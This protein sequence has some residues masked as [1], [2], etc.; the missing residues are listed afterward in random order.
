MS[1]VFRLSSQVHSDIHI[2]IDISQARTFRVI[3]QSLF[4]RLWGILR[5]RDVQLY[6]QNA[7]PMQPPV[8]PRT[9]PSQLLAEFS[10]VVILN[11]SVDAVTAFVCLCFSSLDRTSCTRSVLFTMTP[12]FFGWPSGNPNS[13]ILTLPAFCS[14]SPKIIAKGTPF[15]SAA[16]NC[17]GS[18]GLSL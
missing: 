9:S 15:T 12:S 11:V 5:R 16:L 4:A 14:S 18:F 10:G 3:L 17:A 13:L 6:S 2:W 7:K 8:C 1:E